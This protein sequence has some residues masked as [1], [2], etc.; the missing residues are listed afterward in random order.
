MSEGL[1][2][3][4]QAKANLTLEVLRRRE[5]GFHEIKS[6]MQRITLADEITIEPADALRLTCNR[7]E[8][9]G[10]ENLVWQ[11]AMLLHVE[12]GATL[13]AKIH[14]NKRVPVTAGLGGGSA[15]GAVA[16]AGLNDFW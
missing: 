15:D 2:L 9:E 13:G 3:L 4:A 12:T 8:L 14:L 1:T 16:L 6:V 11:A 10:S 5:D 7:A